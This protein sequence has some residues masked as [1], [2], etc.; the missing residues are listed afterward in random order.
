MCTCK[1]QDH[2]SAVTR[3]QDQNH[4]T[5]FCE[6]HSTMGWKSFIEDIGENTDKYRVHFCDKCAEKDV[7]KVCLVAT[8]DIYRNDF[9]QQC[10]GY[11]AHSGKC[12]CPF[13]AQSLAPAAATP[14]NGW[15]AAEQNYWVEIQDWKELKAYKIWVYDDGKCSD[16]DTFMAKQRA[17]MVRKNCEMKAAAAASMQGPAARV[18]PC[19]AAQAAADQAGKGGNKGGYRPTPA[20]LMQVLQ[21][22]SSVL[23]AVQ[24]KIDEVA[25][26]TTTL[27]AWRGEIMSQLK[28]ITDNLDDKKIDDAAQGD[29]KK[30][31]DK[32]IDDKKITEGAAPSQVSPVITDHV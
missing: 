4:P 5:F 6:T 23:A 24:K 32:N 20:D 1:A 18:Q 9:Q 26:V 16:Y 29:D 28:V 25:D 21:R 3:A 2:H 14:P 8:G 30:I 27:Q 13:H 17:I 15:D 11:W 12:Y 22:Q 19:A 10:R 31:D 7:I